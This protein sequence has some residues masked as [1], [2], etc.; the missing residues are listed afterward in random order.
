M[1][2]YEEHDSDTE[3]VIKSVVIDADDHWIMEGNTRKCGWCM[4]E[5]GI[6][7][8]SYYRFIE[9]DDHCSVWC[10]GKRDARDK[11]ISAR[12]ESANV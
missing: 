12:T 3:L 9:D 2:N 7:E 4:K 5:I 8:R 11:E 1:S 6:G 10:V